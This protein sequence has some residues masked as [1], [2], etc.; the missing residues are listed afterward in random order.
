MG[1]VNDIKR[2]REILE[3]SYELITETKDTKEFTHL[4]QIIG[5]SIT[6]LD[7]LAQSLYL[8]LNLNRETSS[9]PDLA[10]LLD[11]VGSMDMDGVSSPAQDPAADVPDPSK[12]SR[13]EEFQDAPGRYLKLVHRM[14]DPIPAVLD[15]ADCSRDPDRMLELIDRASRLLERVY[16]LRKTK[17]LME[18][19]IIDNAYSEALQ[20]VIE[21]FDLS[22]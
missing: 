15:M 19:D 20:E 13:K 3:R 1:Q 9:S 16:K 7:K 4:M 10:D 6:R 21:K 18:S 17:Q 8:G 11:P 12:M 14:E 5:M 2:F 22:V